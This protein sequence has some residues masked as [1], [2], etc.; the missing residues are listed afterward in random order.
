MPK[1]AKIAAYL[2]IENLSNHTLYRNTYLYSP[3]M[4]EPSPPPTETQEHVN[5]LVICQTKL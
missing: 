5:H 4:G 1:G 2:R 3:Y